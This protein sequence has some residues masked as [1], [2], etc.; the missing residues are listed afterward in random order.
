LVVFQ[1]GF[2]GNLSQWVSNIS[3]EIVLDPLNGANHVV[4]FTQRVSG[5]DL[6]SLTIPLDS[7]VTSTL[8]F[9]FLGMSPFDSTAFIGLSPTWWMFASDPYYALPQMTKDGAWHH[10][11]KDFSGQTS[12][13]IMLEDYV[14]PGSSLGN[15]YFDN[16]T[17]TTVPEPATPVMMASG[18][19]ALVLARRRRGR[20]AAAGV[21][22]SFFAK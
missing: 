19:L 18:W 6:F 4:H 14:W 16:I 12:A 9:D 1:E 5:G 11:S 20:R 22:W 13:T 10:Y 2:E 21:D 17:M 8:S 7:A 15:A 3:G